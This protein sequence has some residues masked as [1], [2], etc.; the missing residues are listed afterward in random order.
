MAKIDELK[1]DDK[2]FNKHTEYGMSLLEKSLRENGAGRSILI[3]KDNNIIAGNGIVEAAGSVGLENI[4]IVET[5]GDE[6]VAVKRTDIALDSEQGRKM[7]LADNATAAADLE[8]DEDLL[9]EASEQWGIDLEDYGLAQN[10]YVREAEAEGRLAEN[11][12]VP[13]MSV[14]DA[15]GGAWQERKKAWNTL[16]NDE[17][18]SRQNLLGEN[19]LMSSVNNGV[20]ILDATLVEVLYKWFMPNNIDYKPQAFD[21]FA[22]DSVGGFVMSYLGAHFTGTELREEQ[23]QLNNER[24]QSRKLDAIYHCDDGRNIAKYLQ[25]ESQDFFFSCPP[26]FDLEHYSN[27][28]R[29]ASNQGS[30]AEFLALLEKAFEESIKCLKK[31]RFAIV[32]MSAVRDKK[33]YYQ[34]IPSDITRIFEKNG[35][36]LYNQLILIDSGATLAL[37]VGNSMKNR[38][39]G[40]QHQEVLVY[41]NGEDNLLYE[42]INE[43]K[44][45]GKIHQNIAVYYK[46]DENSKI[47]DEFKDLRNKNEN[48]A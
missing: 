46:P 5:T 32:V 48:K 47:Q 28:E 3:D 2:N 34:D 43:F 44:T 22:G 30:Y 36:H 39:V 14:L 33:G 27:D 15:R 6:I 12:I 41:F 7:A 23:A 38:K 45:I 42:D 10:K 21:C 4:K 37:R 1:F 35:C 16:I 29:D 31:N 25:P 26:Y 9:A 19:N 8:W 11:F 24:V 40:R 17:G 20:S 13:P 18:E